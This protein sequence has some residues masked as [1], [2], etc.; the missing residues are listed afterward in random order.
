MTS[1]S[2]N[3]AFP[4]SYDA[5]FQSAEGMFGIDRHG[6]ILF[7]NHSAQ[8]I[9]GFAADEVV[10]KSCFNIISGHDR[11]GNLFCFNQC[12]VITMA[13]QRLPI[14]HYDVEATT[15]GGEKIW[16]NASIFLMMEQK[17]REQVIVH[18][19]RRM[20]PSNG[21][22]SEQAASSHCLQPRPE[23]PFKR[24]SLT[25]REMEVLSL[26]GQSL[27]AKEIA[28]RLNISTETARKHIQNLLKKLAAHSKLEAVLQAIRLGLIA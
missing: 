23:S 4:I 8:A 20:S 7:W 10:G 3:V 24:P 12:T 11:S 1:G 16:I 26:M 9:L 18:L 15:K 2:K 17:T 14:H 27:V 13:R 25:P 21:K 22:P 28:N 5:I 6:K 19:F